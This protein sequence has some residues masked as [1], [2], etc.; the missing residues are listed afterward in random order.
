MATA[1]FADAAFWFGTMSVE[2]DVATR[3]RIM[4]RI[5][6]VPLLFFVPVLQRSLQIDIASEE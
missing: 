6:G 3:C 4:R 2:V 1:V 5:V